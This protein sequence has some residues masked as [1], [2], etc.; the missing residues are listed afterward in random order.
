MWQ[1]CGIEPQRAPPF[2]AI[3]PAMSW[4]MSAIYDP[5]MRRSEVAC[6]GAWRRELL[7]ETSGE[8]LEI[9]AGTGVNLPYYPSAVSKLVLSEPDPH[10]RM[11]LQTRTLSV[12]GRDATLTGAGV[13]A[14]P[15]EDESFDFVV[16]TLVLCSVPDPARALAEIH[17]VLRPGG[18][19][20]Y[21]EHVASDDPSRLAWQ[22]RV[23]PLW[24]RIAGNCHLTRR[25]GEALRIAGFEIEQERRESMRKSL[26]LVR[27]SIRGVARRPARAG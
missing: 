15:F 10:M 18:G 8:V 2:A 1:V 25:T 4:F 19:L 17:R 20:V 27:A 26:P 24:K 22:Q 3:V 21:L 12:L 16:S 14:L 9:G 5:F 23:E 13:D 7:G 11:K 6:L